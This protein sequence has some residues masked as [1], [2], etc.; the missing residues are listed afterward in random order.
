MGMLD[1]AAVR[2]C[3]VVQVERGA[4]V[5]QRSERS[6]YMRTVGA[7]ATLPKVAEVDIY[8]ERWRMLEP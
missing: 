2:L 6:L 3:Q 4:V 1:R 7:S 8:S 5:I